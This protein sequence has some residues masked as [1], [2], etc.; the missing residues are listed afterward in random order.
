M[1]PP[2]QAPLAEPSSSRRLVVNPEIWLAALSVVPAVSQALCHS[3]R[4]GSQSL[5]FPDV[6]ESYGSS[7]S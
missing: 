4:K 5:L 7:S 3:K 6:Q 2:Q 1:G